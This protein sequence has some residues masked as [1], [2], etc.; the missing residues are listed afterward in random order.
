LRAFADGHAEL[1]DY[2]RSDTRGPKTSRY[3]ITTVVETDAL[4]EALT[5]ALGSLGRVRKERLLLLVG[6]TRVHLDRVDSLGLPRARRV[7][8]EHENEADG[9]V[10]ARSFLDTLNFHADSLIATAYLQ[11]RSVELI[12]PRL[13][14]APLASLL[15]LNIGTAM[16]RLRA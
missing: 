7:L 14:F 3:G 9:M 13:V 10:E 11:R 8:D 15:R 16:P 4:R 1:I 2:E 6:R 5:R 12:L